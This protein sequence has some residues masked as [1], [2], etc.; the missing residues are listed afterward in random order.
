MAFKTSIFFLPEI[1]AINFF[2]PVLWKYLPVNDANPMPSEQITEFVSQKFT[3]FFSLSLSLS[4][5][6]LLLNLGYMDC[7]S[8][9][10]KKKKRW[11]INIYPS[12]RFLFL[13]PSPPRLRLLS[14]KRVDILD[15]KRAVIE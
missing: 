1:A 4:L 11:S 5:F 7:H 10:K 14:A 8:S 9:M 6:F 2:L 15:V 3:S 12:S 13:P